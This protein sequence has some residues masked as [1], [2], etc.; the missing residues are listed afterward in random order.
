MLIDSKST[1][2][3]IWDTLV[4]ELHRG[5]LDSKHPFRYLNLGTMG[6]DFPEVRT[7]VLRKVDQELNVY[8]YTD[9]RS[10]K[11]QAIQENCKVALHF[12]HP[13]KRV[14]IRIQAE[15]EVHCQDDLA[16]TSWTRV[17]GEAQKA[18]T[19]ILAPG[20]EVEYP[21]HAWQWPENMDDGFFT[22]LKF[23]PQSME[24]LQLD[25][26]NH[27]R[28]RFSREEKNWKGTWLVP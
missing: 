26:L 1:I 28:I 20:R 14:Q 21:E 5:A 12:Y 15:T 22:V 10:D 8:V 18:Y 23:I 6:R 9:S 17:Q 24:V 7:V 16:K 2:S 13:Q 25:G 3:E 11:V 27:L 19:S 4:H